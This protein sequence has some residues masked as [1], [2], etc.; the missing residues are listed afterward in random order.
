MIFLK[1]HPACYLHVFVFGMALARWRELAIR[2]IEKSRSMGGDLCE[3]GFGGQV[4]L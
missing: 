4:R 3:L 1:F 2:E